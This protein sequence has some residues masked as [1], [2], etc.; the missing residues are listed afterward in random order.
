MHTG[1]E[2]CSDNQVVQVP[3]AVEHEYY[4]IVK[5]LVHLHLGCVL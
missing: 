2:D 5:S 1:T 3:C 4:Q